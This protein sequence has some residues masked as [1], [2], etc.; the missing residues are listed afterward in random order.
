MKQNK[1]MYVLA[2]IL[3][4]IPITFAGTI[5]VYDDTIDDGWFASQGYIDADTVSGRDVVYDIDHL[6]EKL[7]DTKEDLMENIE[8]NQIFTWK[9]KHISEE[10]LDN[11]YALEDELKVIDDI[12]TSTT[13]KLNSNEER[14]LKDRTGIDS[15]FLD[16]YLTGIDG[17]RFEYDTFVDFLK[18]IFYSKPEV[19]EKYSECMK[20]SMQN[21]ERIRM[22]SQRLMAAEKRIVELEGGKK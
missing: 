9:V 2:V 17:I 11:T 15:S 7:H 13:N 6:H 21:E 20:Y 4:L 14:Y 22:L 18:T 5:F 16:R 3:A 1:T 8:N 19:D 10:A 12:T